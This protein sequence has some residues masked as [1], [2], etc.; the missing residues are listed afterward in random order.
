MTRKNLLHNALWMLIIQTMI[1][2]PFACAQS[3]TGSMTPFDYTKAWKE[4]QE[5]DDKQ[6]PESALKAVNIIYEHAKQ[7]NNAGQ[8][9]KAVVHQLK[10]TEYKEDDAIAQNLN[11]IRTELATASFP[12]KPLL[13]SMLGEMYWQY[14]QSN[15]Y[16]FQDRTR[17]SNDNDNDVTTWSLDKIV[18]ESFSQYRQSLLE[19]D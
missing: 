1:Y 16:R 14:Y 12:V 13:H 10:F 5:F 4:V 9:V 8:L 11:R 17:I 18:A 7:D 6:L 15:R 19:T 2:V 3:K